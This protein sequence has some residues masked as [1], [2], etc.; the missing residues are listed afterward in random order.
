[1]STNVKLYISKNQLPMYGK[2]QT[3]F[4]S[5][6]RIACLQIFEGGET[7]LCGS[8]VNGLHLNLLLEKNVFRV[9]Q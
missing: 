9:V 8:V 3:S 7:L 4:D 6:L 5:N 1:M 2:K